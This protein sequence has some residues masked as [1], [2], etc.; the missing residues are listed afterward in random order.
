MAFFW[1]GR[2]AARE[3][4]NLNAAK[5]VRVTWIGVGKKVFADWFL[6]VVKYLNEA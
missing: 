1:G 6:Q 3:W 5:V 4:L 2:G